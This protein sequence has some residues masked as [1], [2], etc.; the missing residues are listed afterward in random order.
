[1]ILSEITYIQKLKQLLIRYRNE[2]EKQKEL[3]T[4]WDETILEIQ[5][6]EMDQINDFINFQ[7]ETILHFV[8]LLGVTL[9]GNSSSVEK[10]SWQM[11]DHC[12]F[13]QSLLQLGANMHQESWFHCSPYF[14]A[15]NHKNEE[16]ANFYLSSVF[17]LFQKRKI[18]IILCLYQKHIPIEIIQKIC[19]YEHNPYKYI[20]YLRQTK[21][22]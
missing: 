6:Y 15:Q 18:T 3:K 19:E 22:V 11:Q 16:E 12:Y 17:K 2:F 5:Q 14:H 9:F 10:P 21:L 7:S 20:E 8:F 13:I 4:R 1:M